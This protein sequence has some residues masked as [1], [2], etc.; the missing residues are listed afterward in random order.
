MVELNTMSITT[1]QKAGQKQRFESK[2][3]CVFNKLRRGRSLKSSEPT[4]QESQ[5]LGKFVQ[6]LID[7]HAERHVAEPRAAAS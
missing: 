4:N 5:I 1:G 7:L 3:G 6:L 2:P